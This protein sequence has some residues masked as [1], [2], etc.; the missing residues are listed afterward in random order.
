M[1]YTL[2]KYEVIHQLYLKTGE[3]KIKTIET[4]DINRSFRK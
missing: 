2:N 4:K 1:L 3:R